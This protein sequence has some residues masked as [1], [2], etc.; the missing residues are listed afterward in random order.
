MGTRKY[1]ILSY[2]KNS[3]LSIIYPFPNTCL[4]CN[5][6]LEDIGLCSKCRENIKEIND[7]NFIENVP[8]YSCSYY[9]STIK[10]LIFNLKYKSDFN[11]G[12]I[13]VELA[14][15]RIKK[16][17]IDL[18]YIVYIP[19]SKKKIKERGFNQC[20]FLAQELAK[21]FK[22]ECI[23]IISKNNNVKEQKML[24]K[25]EREKNIK[26]AFKLKNNKNL[27]GKNVLLVD[28]VLTTGFT[29]EE[30]IKELKKINNINLKVLVLARNL[31]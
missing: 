19:S 26:G 10:S 29:I 5:I 30:C 31:L 8:V 1:N 28:D 24:S 7:S 21:E 11:S 20:E 2:L 3:L 12:M 16:E 27:Q 9:A 6:E 17:S 13:L 4:S 25:A 18:D 23:D 22:V 14:V 15:N